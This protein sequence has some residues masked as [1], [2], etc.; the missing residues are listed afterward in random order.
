MD[1]PGV[2]FL[3]TAN[4]AR[5]Q[6]AEALLRKHG[7]DR[8]HVYSAGLDPQGMHPLTIEIMKEI[9][10]SLD[11]HRSK[12]LSEF[13]GKVPIRYVI[14]VCENAEQRCPAVWPYGATMLFWPFIDPAIPAL[15]E[16]AQLEQFRSVRDQI[17]LKIKEWL[18]TI[19][20]PWTNSVED[21]V[22][23]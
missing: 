14:I 4:S 11:G 17:E 5:S 18:T 8:F 12:S 22:D 20:E 15:T 1:R 13:L 10:V 6:M 19:H 7:G 23:E 21:A 3:C 16:E 9:G 2:L